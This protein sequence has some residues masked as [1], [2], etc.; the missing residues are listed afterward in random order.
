VCLMH[1]NKEKGDHISFL[2]VFGGFFGRGFVILSRF[3]FVEGVVVVVI[4]WLVSDL[5]IGSIG[6][7]LGT[8]NLGVLRP[9]C[10]VF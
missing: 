4:V 7:S 8:Q 2:G 3:I 10:I 5:P 1:F 9:R 6:W